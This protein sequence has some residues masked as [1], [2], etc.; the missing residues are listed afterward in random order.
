MF[1]NKNRSLFSCLSAL[2]LT[3]ATTAV[4]AQQEKADEPKDAELTIEEQIE[5]KAIAPELSELR[6]VFGRLD[7]QPSELPISYSDVGYPLLQEQ[8]ALNLSDALQNIAGINVQTGNGPFDAFF[9]RGFDSISSSLVLLDGAVEPESAMSHLYNI[10]RVE[11]VRGGGGFLYGGRALA[12][13][14]NLVRKA[15][16]AGNFLQLGL[17]A[18]SF[19]FFEGTVDGNWQISEHA[20]LRVNGLW[21]SADNFR[22]ATSDVLAINP[23]FV[24]QN[25]RTKIGFQ[26]EHL[27]EERLPDAGVPI[28]FRAGFGSALLDDRER[29][30][31]S[32]FD[33]SEQTLSRFHFDIDHE[34]RDGLRFRAKSYVSNLDWQSKG[35]IHSGAF[36]FPVPIPGSGTAINVPL[37]T[38]IL[39][40][41]DDEQTFANLQAEL[42]WSKKTGTVEHELLMGFE[43]GRQTDNF[44]FDIKLLPVISLRP[45]IIPNAPEDTPPQ[46]LP[47]QLRFGDVDTTI[48][49]PYLVDRI[50]FSDR[51][52]IMIGARFDRVD[53][54]GDGT[55]SDREDSQVSPLL[56]FTFTPSKV[57]SFYAQ[58]SSSFEPPST[59]AVGE[60]VPEEGEQVEVGSRLSLAGGKIGL[61][62]AL[63]QLEKTNLA[64][65]DQTGF[66]TQTGDQESQGVELEL[67]ARLARDFNLRVAYAYTDAELTEFREAF[68][69]PNFGL[70]VVDH[71]GNK[72]S[73]APEHL[74]S[75]WLSKR[76]ENG[77]GAGIGGRYIGEQFINERN[78]F[79]LD[80]YF[81]VDIGLFFNW[82]NAQFN[83]DL[84]NVGDE[85]YETRAFGKDAV[86][87]APGFVARGGIRWTF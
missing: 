54:N 47:G 33:F 48:L 75:F 38:R 62:L 30:F 49:A 78:D 79:G 9:I 70:I 1:A 15:P 20:G 7:A 69:N 56:G 5:V 23:S 29:S 41:L 67:L 34:I 31:R 76:F 80:D 21:Q 44:R 32:P 12:G 66:L 8:G 28:F 2:L 59:L 50:K 74:G 46:P 17:D 3:V 36:L 13:T 35:T 55:A 64:I 85:E 25:E 45:E 37:V 77:F 24:W 52:Q 22:D 39:T 4:A 40:E 73:F 57:A 65:P 60:V 6:S 51:F 72:P 42:A 81:L 86:V 63:Y 16:V 18:G 82:Q 71:S 58:Y 83:V 11:V 26:I 87:P 27:D 84:E 19:S 53:F 61:N 43:V 14:I 68:F 10:E